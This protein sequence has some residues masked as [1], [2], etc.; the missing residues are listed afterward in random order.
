MKKGESEL[1]KNCV[2]WFRYQYPK[3]ALMLFAVPNGGSRNAIEA[4]RLKAEGVTPGV[5][6]LLL[7]IPR[8]RF[9]C[10]GIEL[11]YEK[12]KQSDNQEIWQSEFEANGNKYVLC[13]NF[14]DFKQTIEC[15]L[16]E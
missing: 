4:I 8:G 15:Y 16:K 1:Q 9:G 2:K 14:D 13:N 12:N 11:K 5:A 3:L 6:D 7:T 10:L